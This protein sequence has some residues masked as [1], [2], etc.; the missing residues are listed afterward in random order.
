MAANMS[1]AERIAA[2]K[3]GVPAPATIAQ[4]A[5]AAVTPAATMPVGT[6]APAAIN[7]APATVAQPAPIGSLAAAIAKTGAVAG[8]QPALA[9]AAAASLGG[10][11]RLQLVRD[12]L[13]TASVKTGRNDLPIGTGIFLL[14][15]GKLFITAGQLSISTFSLPCL[16]GIRDG[17]GNVYGVEGYT[18]P[19]PGETY[20]ESIFQNFEPK[21]VVTTIANN[22]RAVT[23]CMGWTEDQVKAFKSTQAGE[24]VLF[25]LIK[26]MMCIDMET[27]APTEQPCCFSNQVVIQMTRRP[28]IV[29]QKDA[30]TKQPLYDAHGVVATKT[31][32]NTF[33]D[34]KIPLPDVLTLIGE[35]ETIKVFG[36]AE[37][38]LA[39][40][41]NENAMTAMS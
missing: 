8:A 15:S 3:A 37:A 11:N 22:L 16:Q 12:A 32:I 41:E 35:P 1:L 10:G 6:P 33:W 34:K 31:F 14:K 13:K 40:V 7:A 27:G 38:Y 20:D 2:A 26:G 30:A 39:A 9:G 29:E 19:I 24:S 4:P 17:A 25:E 18:G 21:R 5:P 36:S 23:A 28:K